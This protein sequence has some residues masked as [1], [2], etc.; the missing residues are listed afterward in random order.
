MSKTDREKRLR[1]ACSGEPCNSVARLDRSSD[2]ECLHEATSAKKA[3]MGDREMLWAVNRSASA[4]LTLRASGDVAIVSYTE[5][6]V[7]LE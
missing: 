3:E 7:R 6:T 5:E 4:P 1:D 2:L